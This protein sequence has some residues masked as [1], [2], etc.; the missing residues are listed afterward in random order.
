M[1]LPTINHIDLSYISNFPLSSLTSSVN[2]RRLDISDSDVGHYG[3]HGEDK[4]LQSLPKIREFHCSESPFSMTAMTTTA[5]FYA[6][7]PDGRPAFNFMDLRRVSMALTLSEEEK[8][9]KMPS[10]LENT[11]YQ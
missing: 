7:R 5:L 3:P 6:K 8:N 4:I 2:L 10:Y 9:R 1:H 11:I